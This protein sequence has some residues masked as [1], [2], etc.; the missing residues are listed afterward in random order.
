VLNL[1][2]VPMVDEYEIGGFMI[3]LMQRRVA[4]FIQNAP[5]VFKIV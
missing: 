4:G 3:V 1:L 2:P 5:A